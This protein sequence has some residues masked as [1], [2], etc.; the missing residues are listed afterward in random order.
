MA[1]FLLLRKRIFFN[2]SAGVVL[3]TVV[4]KGILQNKRPV[5]EQLEQDELV[6]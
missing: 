1:F 3:K 2:K 5:A 4:S 6:C